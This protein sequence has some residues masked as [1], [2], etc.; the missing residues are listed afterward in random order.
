MSR[1]VLKFTG[2]AQGVHVDVPKRAVMNVTV[3]F[4]FPKKFSPATF[5]RSHL[6]LPRDNVFKSL[7]P[8]YKEVSTWS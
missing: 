1:S 3:Y 5:L 6:F 7:M 8:I 4:F 2:G